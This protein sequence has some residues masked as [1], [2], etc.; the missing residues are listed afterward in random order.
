QLLRDVYDEANKNNVALYPVDPRGLAV[1]EFDASDGSIAPGV[2]R[3]FLNSTMDTLR[4]LAVETD[5]RAI[6]NRNDLV[7]G[8]KQIVRD[9][10]AYYLLGYSSTIAPSDGKFHEIK[11]TAKP[12]ALPLPH[13]K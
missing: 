7:G 4:T 13:R 11:V 12:P 9:V 2:D 3:Q 8:M 1:S 10:S 6:V 5:G